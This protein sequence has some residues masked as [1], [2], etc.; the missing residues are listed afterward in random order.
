MFPAR[1]QWKS[2]PEISVYQIP[3]RVL[4]YST[5]GRKEE[6]RA[7]QPARLDRRT[8]CMVRRAPPARIYLR[9]E[10]QGSVALQGATCVASPSQAPD[11]EP[12]PGSL[13]HVRVRFLVPPCPQV[14]EHALNS[15]QQD[16]WPLHRRKHGRT[17]GTGGKERGRGK[18]R[19]RGRSQHHGK[20]TKQ[21]A[22]TK[23][24]PYLPNLLPEAPQQSGSKSPDLTCAL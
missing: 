8:P 20:A 16:H 15:D 2:C 5:L 13:R 4:G 12:E 1:C 23:A 9:K 19:E 22:P 10:G 14:T 21:F 24:E 3:D 7:P 18:E 11:S 17:G 6:R